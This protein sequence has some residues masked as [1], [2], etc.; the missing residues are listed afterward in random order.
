MEKLMYRIYHFPLFLSGYL[1]YLGSLV[2]IT[3]ICPLYPLIL[4]CLLALACPIYFIMKSVNP[5]L[6][7]S[8]T[9]LTYTFFKGMFFL[10]MC[11][12]IIIIVLVNIYPKT[13]TFVFQDGR[14]I[15][16]AIS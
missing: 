9:K 8:G 4:I 1:F 11:I 3:I 14:L 12:M 13:E 10:H 2:M 15:K 16:K 6:N 7:G 5:K